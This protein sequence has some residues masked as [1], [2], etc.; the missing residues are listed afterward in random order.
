[1]ARVIRPVL[2]IRCVSSSCKTLFEVAEVEKGKTQIVV[3]PKCGEYYEYPSPE[4]IH[5]D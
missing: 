1:M 5:Q 4:N 3:C 2:A